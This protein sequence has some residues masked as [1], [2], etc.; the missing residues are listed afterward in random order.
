[1]HGFAE[2]HPKLELAL[3]LLRL[4]LPLDTNAHRSRFLRR[5]GGLTAHLRHESQPLFRCGS[6]LR[7]YEKIERAWLQRL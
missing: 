6:N 4:P 2:L 3:L 1:V 5:Y 7:A